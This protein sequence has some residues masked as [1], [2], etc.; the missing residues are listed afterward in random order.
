MSFFRR[1]D[2]TSDTTQFI[3]Q[4]KATRPGLEAS[5]REGRARLWDKQIDREFQAR[6]EAARV[7][8]KPYVYQTSADQA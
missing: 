4:L 1:P 7:P 3:E 8:Q 6:A 5:Q 2:Y